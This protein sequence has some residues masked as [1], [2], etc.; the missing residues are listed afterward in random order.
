MPMTAG[1][2][3]KMWLKEQQDRELR[4]RNEKKRRDWAAQQKQYL[5]WRY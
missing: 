2:S 3:E 5:G 4:E 1:G